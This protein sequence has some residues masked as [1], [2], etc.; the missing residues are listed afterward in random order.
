MLIPEGCYAARC[1]L[2]AY[3]YSTAEFEKKIFVVSKTVDA[4]IFVSWRRITEGL[5][6]VLRSLR[7]STLDLFPKPLQFQ[8]RRFID[9]GRGGPTVV[10]RE[11]RSFSSS[12]T[13]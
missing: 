12:S 11:I 2:R 5:A 10:S 4:S 7:D 1:S 3:N 13:S 8:E 6:I 9:R